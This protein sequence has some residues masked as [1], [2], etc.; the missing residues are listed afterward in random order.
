MPPDVIPHVTDVP[1]LFA[2]LLY[3]GVFWMTAWSLIAR[4]VART[5]AVLLAAAILLLSAYLFLGA[6]AHHAPGVSIGSN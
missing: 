1:R 6:I 4:R 3:S 5:D 2:A